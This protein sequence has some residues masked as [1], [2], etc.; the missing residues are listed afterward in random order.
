MRRWLSTFGALLAGGLLAF[1]LVAP[2]GADWTAYHE[3]G[4]LSAADH[5]SGR[6]APLKPAWKAAGL[7]G[8][9]WSEPLVYHGL[10]IVA[11]EANDIYAFRERT[12]VRVWHARLGAP[13]PAST[14]P[15]G[16]ISPTVGITGTPVIDP[17]TDT[18]YAVADL[19]SGASARHT[20]FALEAR[21]GRRRFARSV[22]PPSDPL[23]QLQR[24]GLALDAG[25]VLIGFGGNDGDCGQ[26]RGFL[27][28]AP[29]A[30]RGANTIYAVPTSREGAIWSGGGAPAVDRSGNVF[31]PTGNAANGP[32]QAYDH[33]DTLEKLSPTGVQRDFWAPASWARD[34]AADAD[35]G[36]VSPVLL[37]G[38]LVYQGGKN[39]RG[40]LVS[41]RHLG[42]IGGELFSAPVCTS[43]GADAY[44]SGTL[45][46]A[47]TE[48]IHA[49]TVKTAAHRF[50][51]RWAGPS[52]ADG[53]PI[54]AAGR[55][56][57][58][59][60]S[61]SLL[62]GL[63]PRTGAVRARQSTPAMEHFSTP[64]ASG[65]RLFLATGQTLNAY[66]IGTA[67]LHRR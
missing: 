15:C 16:D 2:A 66:T 13:V 49:L 19:R 17:R 43:F 40:Y 27:V 59:S 7:D 11:T 60:T 58:T 47:C 56:W 51:N 22:E 24:E 8:T 30:N 3:G 62:Y 65:G 64:A 33:G 67:A 48:G 50:V 63:D 61:D 37:P 45:F 57:V 55:V 32:G 23:N 1:G 14:L 38:H 31:V 9:V 36:S 52:D 53:P 35:L 5:S 18:L 20:L 12:G 25:R 41:T 21:T 6:A 4:A 44:A 39:G 29:A 42:H 46:V 10:V 54:L 28:S 26:Y 34:S